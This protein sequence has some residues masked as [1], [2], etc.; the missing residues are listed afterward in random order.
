MNAV[1][2]INRSSPL[3]KTLTDEERDEIKNKSKVENTNKATKLWVN[4]FTNYLNEKEMPKMED[5]SK[6]DL[7]SV[8]ERYYSELKKQKC[9]N[10]ED[11]DSD[12]YKHS[13]QKSIRAALCRHFKKT[14]CI[15]IINSEN[16]IQANE[17]FDGVK[18]VSKEKGYG[19]VD[20]YPPIEDYNLAKIK[21]FI[22]P[23]IHG[24]PSQLQKSATD[25]NILYTFFHV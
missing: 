22:L 7:P 9:S 2:N 4:N 3:F 15:D 24:R 17:M 8:L 18:R 10:E 19:N 11:E 12:T 6:E 13:T 21:E 1:Q 20:S 23:K 25:S 14:R 16:F 5:I